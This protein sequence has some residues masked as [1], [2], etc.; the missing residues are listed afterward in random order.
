MARHCCEM[1]TANVNQRCDQ[2]S[3]PFECPDNLVIFFAD[4]NEYGLIVHDGGSSFVR[5]QFCPWCGVG[6]EKPKVGA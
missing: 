3:D 6:L 1:M 2:H 5:I 4:R